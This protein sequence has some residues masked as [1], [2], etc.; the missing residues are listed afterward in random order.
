MW[1]SLD[2]LLM[3]LT[4]GAEKYETEVTK[5]TTYNIVSSVWSFT[6]FCSLRGIAPEVTQMDLGG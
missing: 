3:K 4:Y 1:K 2:T 6:S 5:T